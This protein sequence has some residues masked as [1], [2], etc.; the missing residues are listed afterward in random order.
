[1]PLYP[2]MFQGPN[3][4]V[5]YAGSDYN[6]SYLNP[7]YVNPA[8]GQQGTWTD[9]FTPGGRAFGNRVYGTAAMFAP[10]QIL[11]AG[12]CDGN[13]VTNTA[14]I[15]D[16][17][18]GV[19]T[20]TG[21]DGVSYKQPVV[22]RAADMRNA[23]WHVNSTILPD[24]TVLATGG[25]RV[26]GAS[27]RH[28]AVMEAEIWSPPPPYGNG[29][30]GTGTW[31]TVAPMAE[32]RMYHST[33]VLLPDGRVLS[34][35][36]EEN[37]KYDPFQPNVNN[38]CTA[39]LYSPPYLFDAAGNPRVRPTI[40]GAPTHV[41]Y[42]QPFTVVA[43]PGTGTV[44][45]V[46]LVRLS[47]VTHS[48]N[49]NQRFLEPAKG[50]M[51]TAQGATSVPLTAPADGNVCPPG[52]Y[53]LFVLNSDGV[54]SVGQV[55]QIDASPCAVAPVLTAAY[56]SDGNCAA[57]ATASVAGQNLGTDYRWTIDGVAD[58]SFDGQPSA[59][60]DL[61]RCRPQA[62]L[63]VRVTPTCGGPAVENFVSVSRGF[64]PG[65]CPACPS[66]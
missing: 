3:G 25:S 66:P 53:W 34:A 6:L 10:G 5:F 24:G 29:A 48:F 37:I 54:P 52:H 8:N 46:T 20:V 18:G 12:G 15:L 26:N 16:L 64:S 9:V 59:S 58:S 30:T 38:H 2:W 31:T 21:Q 47:S 55:V 56:L 51:T 45:R 39:E 50:A 49:M 4:K 22:T 28:Q 62:T 14:E 57:T 17:T 36:G 63:G 61:S 35:G 32:A 19:T 42:G 44:A 11:L 27:D 65:N 1:M 13:T 23:R 33:A 40:T 43:R 7:T 60:V 41:G